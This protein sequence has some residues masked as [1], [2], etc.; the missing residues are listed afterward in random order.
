M[1]SFRLTKKLRSNLYCLCSFS[2]S[3]YSYSFPLDAYLARIAVSPAALPPPSLDGLRTL[4][5]G[6]LQNIPFEDIDIVNGKTISMDLPDVVDKLVSK[7]RGGYCFEQNT[8]FEAALQSLGYEVI[9]SLARVRY[10]RPP[11]VITPYT[12]HVLLVSLG[13]TRYLVD[14]GFGGI[15]CMQPLSIDTREEQETPEGAFRIIED[16]QY[17]KLQWRLKSEFTDLYKFLPERAL[18]CD[19]QMSN[20]WSCTRPDARWVSHLFAA[21]IIGNERHH[22]LNSEYVIRSASGIA[23]KR[24]L[25]SVQEL[26]DTLTT[27]FGIS[28]PSDLDIEKV[29][30]FFDRGPSDTFHSPRYISKNS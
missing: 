26:L 15:N 4:M 11:E 2:M 22:V 21:R 28:L 17:L 23:V 3:A 7:K 25:S 6:H 27:V 5:V 16:D 18:L 12:H 8:L 24:C 29:R 20:W 13:G 19:M 14:V 9:S 1:L 30:V 10:N